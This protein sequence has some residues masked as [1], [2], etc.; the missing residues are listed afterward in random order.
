MHILCIHSRTHP[1][2]QWLSRWAAHNKG[3][4]LD[5]WAGQD[6]NGIYL[7]LLYSLFFVIYLLKL[8]AYVHLAIQIGA[9][10]K[11][12]VVT[13]LSREE[14][15]VSPVCHSGPVSPGNGSNSTTGSKAKET[16][17]ERLRLCAALRKLP[18]FLFFP[19]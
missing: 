3:S 11:S 7:T 2:A 15:V 19:F 16:G 9:G 4:G 10:Y 5:S 13:S 14:T 6:K 8:V 12:G 1:V 18:S 17:D